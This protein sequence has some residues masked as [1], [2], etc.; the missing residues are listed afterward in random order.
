ME[1]DVSSA[2]SQKRHDTRMTDDHDDR[3]D[4]DDHEYG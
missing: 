2:R 3:D 4:Y 1:I